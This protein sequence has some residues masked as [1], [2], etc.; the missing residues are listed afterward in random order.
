MDVVQ[1]R[2]AQGHSLHLHGWKFDVKTG[3]LHDLGVTL[4]GNAD[5]GAAFTMPKH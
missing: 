5:L 4:K 1:R 3:T 2:W